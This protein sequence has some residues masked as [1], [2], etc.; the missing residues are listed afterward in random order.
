MSSDQCP[1]CRRPETRR[2]K[3]SDLTYMN[4]KCEDCHHWQYHRYK[5]R[6]DAGDS[7][8]HTEP[9]NAPACRLFEKRERKKT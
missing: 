9:A 1:R 4:A 3:M 6:C 5:P 7:M 2:K 8:G